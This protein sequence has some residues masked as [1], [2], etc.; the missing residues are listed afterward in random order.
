M[1]SSNVNSVATARKTTSRSL[2]TSETTSVGMSHNEQRYSKLDQD[3]S[4]RV[5]FKDCNSS[6]DENLL[7]TPHDSSIFLSSPHES[8][9][10]ITKEV[11]RYFNYFTRTSTDPPQHIESSYNSSL[12]YIPNSISTYQNYGIVQGQTRTFDGPLPTG[13][14]SSPLRSSTRYGH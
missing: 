10:P 5:T 12:N 9:A 8:E 7:R 1:C 4:N 2:F 14:T 11:T 6:V 13:T 3:P